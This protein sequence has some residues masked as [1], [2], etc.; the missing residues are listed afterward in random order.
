[1][2]A[3]GEK[4]DGRGDCGENMKVIVEVTEEHIKNGVRSFARKCALALALKDVMSPQ[5][6]P[7]VCYGAVIVD[8]YQPA[9]L[10]ATSIS[11]FRVAHFGITRKADEFQKRFDKGKKVKPV[12]LQL[13]IPAQILKVNHPSS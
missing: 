4:E 13:D 3:V 7:Y 1:M 8:F 5:H 10:S 11:A 9:T 6:S 12:K 2:D